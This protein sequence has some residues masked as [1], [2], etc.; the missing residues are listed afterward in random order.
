MGPRSAL[1]S[2]ATPAVLLALLLSGTGG[3]FTGGGAGVSPVPGSVAP[4]PVRSGAS[5][6]APTPPGHV[7]S[8]RGLGPTPSPLPAAVGAW[9]F[10]EYGQNRSGYSTAES[11]LSRTN[12][13]KL[14]L[15]WNVTLPGPVVASPTEV[16]GTV[17][18]GSWDGY[19][20]A[21]S[22]ANGSVRWKTFLGVENFSGQSYGEPWLTPLGVSAA[23]AVVGPTLYVGAFHNYYALNASTGSILW[24][25]SVVNDTSAVSDGYYAWS[26][27]LVYDGNVYAGVSSQIDN[28]LVPGGVD[29]YNASTGSWEGQWFSY[30]G[31][32]GGSVWASP[33]LDP[34]KNTVWVTTGNGGGQQNAYAAEAMV[35]LNAS[36]L[37]QLG[38][39]NVVPQSGQSLPNDVDFGAGA[40][41]FTAHHWGQYVVATNKDGYAYAFNGTRLSSGP[42]WS[43]QTTSYPAPTSCQ[44]P[45]QAISPGVWDGA[46]LY[47][48]SSFTTVRG[49]HVNG[50]VRAVYPGNGTYR[51]QA[52]TPGTVQAG[53]AAANGLVVAASHLYTYGPDGQGCDHYYGTNQSWLQVFNSSDGASLFRYALAY[54][55]I[56]APTIA[57]GRIFVGATVNDT[58]SWDTVPDHAGHVFAFGVPLEAPAHVLPFYEPEFNGTVGID[59]WGNATGGMPSYEGYW[60]WGDGSGTTGPNGTHLYGSSPGT[61]NATFTATD[62]ADTVAVTS[63]SVVVGYRSNCPLPAQFCTTISVSPVLAPLGDRTSN[64]ANGERG[65]VFAGP[66]PGGPPSRPPAHT[67]SLA[68]AQA[69]GPVALPPRD[70]QLAIQAP[71]LTGDGRVSADPLGRAV[72]AHRPRRGTPSRA[73]SSG[74]VLLG[75]RG[76]L[77]PVGT[78]TG[79]KVRPRRPNSGQ[80]S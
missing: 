20:Y 73:R 26:S 14:V 12:A 31:Y 71:R 77:S 15:L 48:G 44:P 55:I 69:V 6:G 41:E 39:W 22:A 72:G 66:G 49:A 61:Y 43:D 45:G 53:L 5:A 2:V 42:V 9:P 37:V 36:T 24:N 60:S 4:P 79:S 65:P 7:E 27:P 51:W 47:L 30:G 50:S 74:G 34:A 57:D 76:P 8:A 3:N 80:P 33:T 54:P 62:A 11:T 68:S 35:G 29:E 67:G 64:L 13:A 38:E 10:Y 63:F 56:A 18:V 17:Y 52:V 28:P 19:E 1:L 32:A 40:T 21:L 23:A 70:D 58:S 59:A 25:Q 16:N 78:G 75:T 46:S